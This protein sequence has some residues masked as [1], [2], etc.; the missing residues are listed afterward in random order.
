MILDSLQKSAMYE[1]LHPLFKQ[2]FHYVKTTDF[3]KIEQGR[4][5][6]DG[7]SLYVIYTETE[8]RAIEKANME[9]HNKY[10][11]IHIPLI[12]EESMGY[13][14]A[15]DLK[16]PIDVYN[17]EKDIAFFTNKATTFISVAPSQFVIFFPKEGHEPAIGDGPFLKVIVKIKVD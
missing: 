3:S 4:I 13:C 17:A 5:E 1:G 16:N 10:I 14:P 8:G 6:L 15:S 2:A 9:S 7:N 12:L 11:D